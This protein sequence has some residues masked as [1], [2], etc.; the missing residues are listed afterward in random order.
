M[1]SISGDVFKQVLTDVK[2]S[3]CTD[4][5]LKPALKY[6][7]LLVGLRTATINQM[8]DI[9]K[10]MLISFI[11]R[12]YSGHTVSELR[13]AFDL[14]V[15]GKLDV[16]EVNCYENFTCEY[17]GKIMTA[18][19]KWAQHHF[20]EKELFKPE[21]KQLDYKPTAEQ[22]ANGNREL[23]ELRYQSFLTG[24]TEIS[25]LP[26]F[27]VLQLATDGITDAEIW[28]DFTKHAVR[29]KK[30]ELATER[31]LKI[32][33]GKGEQAKDLLQQIQALKETDENII[34]LA[35]KLALRFCFEQFKKAERKNIYEHD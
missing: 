15:A 31:E 28:Q 14:A 33:Q 7:M 17:L 13:L 16:K 26:E 27:G 30:I 11:R 1:P 29:H 10:V 21:V 22:L 8:D 23:I 24:N 18:Y 32:M 5:Q 34:A 3:S 9:E 2:I 6:V 25:F 4:E 12:H 19:R 20:D 35:K